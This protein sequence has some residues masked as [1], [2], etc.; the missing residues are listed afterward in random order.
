MPATR[1]IT[2]C[3]RAVQGESL[4]ASVGLVECV[5]LVHKGA[6]AAAVEEIERRCT[7]GYQ[8]GSDEERLA[9]LYERLLDREEN[10]FA[11][12][13]LATVKVEGG[14]TYRSDE[15]LFATTEINN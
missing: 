11:E 5:G 8:R 15:Q 3:Q 13:K 10:E 4:E 9:D 1:A 6:L 2:R 12:S 7:D 14:S